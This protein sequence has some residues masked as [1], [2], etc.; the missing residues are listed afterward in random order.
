M[1]AREY[2]SNPYVWFDM[3]NEPQVTSNDTWKKTFQNMV[4]QIRST[5]NTN[6]VVATGNWWGH[7]ANDWNC[8]NVS[9]SK[10]ALLSQQ[11]NNPVGIIAYGFHAYDQ[12]TQCQSKMDDFLDRLLAK[13]KC[14]IVGEYGVFNNNDVSSVVEFTLSVAAF[15]KIGRIAWA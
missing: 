6:I 2:K 11:L 12:W 15:P 4:D 9:D 3:F 8:S 10:S 5:G 7:D 1:V 14:V 13:G